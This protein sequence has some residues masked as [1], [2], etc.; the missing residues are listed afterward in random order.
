MRELALPVSDG[1][2]FY[3]WTYHDGSTWCLVL[4]EGK[5]LAKNIVAWAGVSLQETSC[6]FV[7]VFVD[8]ERRGYG[9]AEEL[10][11]GLLDYRRPVLEKFQHMYAASE[12]YPKY[13]SILA[14]RGWIHLEW[15]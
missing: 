3:R 5:A 12:L 9:Y 8:S 6:P 13:K 4:C 10:V 11:C 15:E 14:D 2:V 7:G 1:G